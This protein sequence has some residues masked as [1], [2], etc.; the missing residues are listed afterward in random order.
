MR[1]TLC[2]SRAWPALKSIGDAI[3]TAA[4]RA[5]ISAIP[6][7]TEP[8]AP[9]SRPARGRQYVKSPPHNPERDGEQRAS[10]RLQNSTGMASAKFPQKMD[11]PS[12][13]R[14]TKWREHSLKS[15]HDPAIIVALPEKR[16]V[17]EFL[18]P[19]LGRLEG[20]GRQEHAGGD[21]E[22]Q[23]AG[24]EPEEPPL[25]HLDDQQIDADGEDRQERIDQAAVDHER[26]IDQP[27]AGRSRW[28]T[29]PEWRRRKPPQAPREEAASEP[30]RIGTW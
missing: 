8:E 13:S 20:R 14:L 27:V 4:G 16:P 5:Q 1:S 23:P 30:S 10:R 21:E 3:R 17:D 7:V 22:V 6:A 26:D 19:P 12:S 29:R 11:C 9:G 18:D 15:M 25:G 2:R 28:Q 24:E